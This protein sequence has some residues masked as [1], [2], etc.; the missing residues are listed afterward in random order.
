MLREALT[1]KR[2][3]RLHPAAEVV[4]AAIAIK[5]L[6]RLALARAQWCA[7][8]RINQIAISERSALAFRCQILNG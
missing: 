6:T 8:D 5:C 1:D 4:S 2:R 3:E 7:V